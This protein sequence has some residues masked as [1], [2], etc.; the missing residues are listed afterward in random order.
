MR[1]NIFV[2]GLKLDISHPSVAETQLEYHYK[3]WT[4]N[5]LTVDIFTEPDDYYEGREE[6]YVILYRNYS[7]DYVEQIYRTMENDRL[8][9]YVYCLDRLFLLGYGSKEVTGVLD[10]TKPAPNDYIH[11]DD[12]YKDYCKLARENHCNIPIT[13]DVRDCKSSVT[14]VLTF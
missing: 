11:I 3:L 7:E 2:G 4:G 12:F 14:L 6:V 13:I 10:L 8:N 1:N 5:H 9:P